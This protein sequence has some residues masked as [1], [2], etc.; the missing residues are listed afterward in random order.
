[1][2]FG[3]P[4]MGGAPMDAQLPGGPP[5]AQPSGKKGKKPFGKKGGFSKGGPRGFGGGKSPMGGGRY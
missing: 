3:K 2:A 5:R 4:P 1:M